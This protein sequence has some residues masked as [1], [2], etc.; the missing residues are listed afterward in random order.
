MSGPN[1]EVFDQ[2]LQVATKQP[3]ILTPG[4][5]S[6]QEHPMVEML[7]KLKYLGQAIQAM[8]GGMMQMQDI[9]QRLGQGLD[10]AHLQ[11]R[12]ITNI[13]VD[14]NI[15]TIEELKEQ[16]QTDVVDELKK[17]RAAQEEKMKEAMEQAQAGVQTRDTKE[18]DCTECTSCHNHE[19]EEVEESEA[20]ESDV[21]LPSERNETVK[22]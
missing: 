16:Y 18:H 7:G 14:K 2:L 1:Q 17:V 20:V 21:V 19:E 11:L 8:D 5:P 3:D 15:I 12:M 9:M 22:F 6:S 10:I 4:G 13:L